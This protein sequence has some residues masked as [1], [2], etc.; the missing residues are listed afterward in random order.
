MGKLKNIFSNAS[1][2]VKS[3][4]NS[5]QQKAEKIKREAER[6]I[7]EAKRKQEDAIHKLQREA[8]DKADKINQK[9][10]DSLAK[11]KLSAKD[12]PYA[13]L[14]PFKKV[15]GDAVLTKGIQHDGSLHDIVPKF[16]NVIVLPN[17]LKAGYTNIL[18]GSTIINEDKSLLNNS[19]RPMYTPNG[20]VEPV[21]SFGSFNKSGASH[22]DAETEGGEGGGES[23]KYEESAKQTMGIISQILAWFKERKAKKQA[24]KEAEERSAITGE[25]MPE[26]Y[27]D[28]STPPI[29]PLEDIILSK[30]DGIS[31]Q[32]VGTAS[33]EV[34]KEDDSIVGG[35]S[36]L[37]IVL[38]LAGTILVCVVV[39][40]VFFK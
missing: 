3:T 23:A 39:K 31:A 28:P 12:L 10:K 1:K 19:T 27:G 5:A 14:L 17:N 37:E 33:A 6:Q 4:V 36:G 30:A 21:G 40:K 8:Q 34:E 18:S 35:F 32:I 29:N 38:G 26:N 16:L 7:K 24:K 2:G 15:M 9:I 22:F 11:V 20:G 13:Q 25:P